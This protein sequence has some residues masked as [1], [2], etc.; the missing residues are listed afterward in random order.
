MMLHN[1]KGSLPA[2]L[3]PAGTK[4]TGPDSVATSNIQ[5]QMGRVNLTYRQAK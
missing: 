4:K 3:P 5:N 2:M 1:R